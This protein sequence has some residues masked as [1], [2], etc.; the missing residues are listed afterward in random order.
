MPIR[1]D[2]AQRHVLPRGLDIDF[3]WTS[4]SSSSIDAEVFEVTT[5]LDEGPPPSLMVMM[6][7]RPILQLCL[8]G[9]I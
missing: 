8:W 6:C 2:T 1:Q 7:N 4:L 9:S 3:I 5:S